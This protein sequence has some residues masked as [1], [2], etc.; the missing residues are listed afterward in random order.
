MR[1]FLVG[2]MLVGG[3]V[4]G[5]GAAAQYDAGIAIG[6]KAPVISINDLDGKP[7]DLGAFNG[8]KPGL[9][10]CWATRCTR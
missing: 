10:E 8:K 7:T 2:L 1:G 3:A 6:S 4:L 5:P 9:L